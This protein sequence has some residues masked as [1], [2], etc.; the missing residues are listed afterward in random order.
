MTVRGGRGREGTTDG[1][2]E[3]RVVGAAQEESLGVGGFGECFG[4]VDA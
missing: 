4:E 3:Q 2:L 1:W